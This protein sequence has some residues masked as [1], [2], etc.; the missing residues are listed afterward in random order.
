MMVIS[1]SGVD[2]LN[3][4]LPLMNF[5]A[6][7]EVTSVLG[8]IAGYIWS[9]PLVILLVGSGVYFSI[10]LVFPQ[11]RRIGH[12]IAVARGKYDNPDDP[13]DITHFQA[14]CAALSATVGVGNI[15]G[16]AIALHAGGPG[17]VFW[18]WIA[19]LF[20]MVTKYAECTLAQKYRVIHSDG[21]IS[22]G[23]MY[24]IEKGMGSRFKW[25]AIVFASCGLIATFG[26]GN[27]VQSNSMVIAFTDQFATQKFYN[28]TPLSKLNN[29]EKTSQTEDTEF[30]IKTSNGKTIGIDISRAKTVS[31]FLNAINDHQENMSQTVM[32]EIATDNNSIEFTDLT[33]GK[34]EF[35]LASPDGSKL[36]KNLGFVND[37]G[38]I[39]TFSNGKISTVIP[40]R[41]LLKAVLGVAISL[42][43]GMV[44]IGGIKRI[45]KV[46]SRLVPVMSLIYVAGAL[47]II[48][49]NYDRILDSFY[50]I[51]KHAFTP[52][53]ATGGFAGATV[54][55]AITWGVR[56]AAFSNEA[57]L[58]SAPIAHAAAKTKEPVREGLVAMMGPLIDT[59]IICTMTALVIIISGEWTGNA[60]SS[61]LTKN[62]FNAGIPYFGGVIVA[63]GL[64]LFAISTAISWSYYGD[65]CAEYL[66]GSRAILPYRWIYVVALFVGA[67][68]RLEFVWNFSDI[69]LG[70]MA[71]PNL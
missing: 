44:I 47:F 32:A 69:T 64:I 28:D 37:N 71:L 66:F 15:A 20:G 3:V 38:N 12:G 48:L 53:A 58:G 7:D 22:G 59:L 23:P 67:V 4:N 40:E 16:V 54:L 46:A 10:R 18:M 14:L 29:G 57:G 39:N 60:D 41:L 24:Y 26:G 11:F 13:G 65:R 19:A 27:M 42:I 6:L 1:L 61:V 25:L 62:A 52:T 43:V 9:M 5:S 34:H 8:K 49:W 68:V 35:T 45:G 21:S 51:F 17:A 56:R 55:Y 36:I 70:L 63:V 33:E 2:G 50:L 30:I 31:D